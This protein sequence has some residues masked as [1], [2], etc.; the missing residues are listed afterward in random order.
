MARKSGS[1]EKD[2]KLLRKVPAK[3]DSE[4]L[5]QPVCFSLLLSNNLSDLYSFIQRYHG[6]SVLLW[7]TDRQVRWLTARG[8]VSFSLCDLNCGLLTLV[9]FCE[10]RNGSLFYRKNPKTLVELCTRVESLA[11]GI[12]L[13]FQ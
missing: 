12:T 10:K 5:R 3:G 9:L 2:E 4:A 8:S 13:C 6:L 1:L 11:G 7:P